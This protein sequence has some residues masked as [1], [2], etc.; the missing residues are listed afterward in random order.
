M[1]EEVAVEVAECAGHDVSV[2]EVDGEMLAVIA[3]GEEGLAVVEIEAFVN[4]DVAGSDA[5]VDV[6][7]VADSDWD[8]VRGDAKGSDSVVDGVA[9]VQDVSTFGFS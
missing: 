8:A 1:E 3:E 6:A 9:T 4:A 2:E 5:E 7:N